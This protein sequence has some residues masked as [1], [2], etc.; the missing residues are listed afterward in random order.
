MYDLNY[1]DKF[2]LIV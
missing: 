1:Y 2:Y